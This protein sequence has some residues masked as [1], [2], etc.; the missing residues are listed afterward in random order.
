[1]ARSQIHIK[2]DKYYNTIHITTE[3]DIKMEWKRTLHLSS[4][5]HLRA[6][7]VVVVAVIVVTIGW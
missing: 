3:T 4:F 5:K 1:M 7:I 2:S 6:T